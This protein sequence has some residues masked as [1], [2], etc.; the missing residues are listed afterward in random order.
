VSPRV[1]HLNYVRAGDHFYRAT[2][3]Q[4]FQ[5]LADQLSGTPGKNR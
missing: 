2:A 5:A 1:Q 3:E 4:F